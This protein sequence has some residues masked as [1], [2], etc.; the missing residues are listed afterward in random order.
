MDD[1][2]KNLERIKESVKTPEFK[3]V[4]DKKIAKIK[5]GK[6]VLK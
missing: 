6:E 4:I 2:V 5:K 1:R 3:E